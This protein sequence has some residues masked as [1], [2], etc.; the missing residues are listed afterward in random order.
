[1]ATAPADPRTRPD[2][3]SLREP[4][5]LIPCTTEIPRAA[6]PQ[7]WPRAERPLSAKVTGAGRTMD[8]DEFLALTCTTS[9]VVIVDGTLVHERYFHGV[10]P[11]DRL[12]GNS[13]TKSALALLV[14]DIPE[15]DIDAPA[16]SYVPELN[17]PACG[18]RAVTIRHLLAMTTGVDWV[19]DHRDPASPAAR[20]VAPVREGKGGIREQ[21]TRIP[22]GRTPGTSFTY[23]TAD[24][25]VLDWVR[26]RA[27]GLDFA[28][29]LSRLWDALGAE[30]PAVVGHDRHGVAMA[31]GSLA[32]TARDWARLGW[33][34]MDGSW[35]GRGLVPQEW[36][37][38]TSRPGEPFLHPGRLPVTIT[39]HAGFGHHWWPLDVTGRRVT[40]DGMRGQFVYADRDRRVVVVKTSAW[41]HGDA[42]ADM[43]YRD[44]CYLALPAI[45]E[46]AVRD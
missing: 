23:C 11:E 39:A 40:A 28:T 2:V 9:L 17:D 43:Q 4:Q 8:L 30:H 33:L 45:A 36:T 42:W 22:P 21:L 19:E 15:L 38:T 16:R 46:A 26:E 12:L 3:E 44:L 37:D 20:L 27:T 24:S 10:T 25:L 35:G 13:A 14:G 31:G 6:A 5:R 29:H 32:A 18:Y 41:P 34:Q 7:P 1:M